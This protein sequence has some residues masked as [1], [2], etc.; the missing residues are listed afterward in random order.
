MYQFRQWCRIEPKA[1]L[2]NG[3]NKA[4]AGF[5]IWVVKLAIARVLLEVRGI[6]WR[7]KSA[8]M[9][10][11]PPSDL[12]RTGIFE[13]YNGIFIAIKIGFVEQRA[14]AVKQAGVD[15]FN[16]IANAVCIESR[17]QG[18]RRGAVKTPVVIENFNFQELP[19]SP[20]LRPA[21]SRP[22]RLKV[23]RNAIPDGLLSSDIREDR[24]K[25]RRISEEVSLLRQ[26]RGQRANHRQFITLALGCFRYQHCPHHHNRKE[27]QPQGQPS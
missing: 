16:I 5:E 23:N 4:G 9:V 18:R 20:R 12:R 11:K 17:K 27:T 2:G 7:Q 8:L 1:L 22:M 25:S 6:R 3:R 13:I 24:I 19:F 26:P 15:E 10:V 21:E 14:C